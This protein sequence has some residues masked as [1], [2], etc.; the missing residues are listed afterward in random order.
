MSS[1]AEPRN[2]VQVD[3]GIRLKTKDWAPR[4]LRVIR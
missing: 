3:L 1:Q 4:P 2:E